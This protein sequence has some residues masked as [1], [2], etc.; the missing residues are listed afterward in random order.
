[1][2]RVDFT[3]QRVPPLRSPSQSV[4]QLEKKKK[5]TALGKTLTKSYL[6]ASPLSPGFAG[7][8]CGPKESAFCSR[9]KEEKL[10][11]DKD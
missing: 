2:R 7:R 1:C 8:L 3:V 6:T 11:A 9:T 5:H 4:H 10:E